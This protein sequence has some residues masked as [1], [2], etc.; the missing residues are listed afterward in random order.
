M[1]SNDKQ[2]VDR[3][4]QERSD[5]GF[6]IQRPEFRR[7]LWRVIQTSRIFN[8][9]STDGSDKRDLDEGRRDLGLEI[10]SMVED[11]QPIAHRHPGGP[12]LTVAM[13][14]NEEINQPKGETHVQERFDRSAELD[15][16]GVDAEAD[17]A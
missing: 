3:E 5:I 7:F 8:P 10:L 11:G 14:L 1:A 13:A 16:D 12:I 6:L 15:D 2:P 17:R 9:A 4:K